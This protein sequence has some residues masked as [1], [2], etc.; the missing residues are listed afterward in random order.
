[1]ID[2]PQIV[3]SP[4]QLTAVI[5]LTIPRKEI[6][7]VM[8]PAI[9]EVMAAVAA[10]GIAPSGPV[11]S[12]HFRMDPGIFDFEVGVPIPK[13]VSPAG[14]VKPGQLPATTVARTVYHGPYEGLGAAWGEFDAWIAANGHT[15][16]PNLWERYVAGP[17]SG[18]DPANW[19][20]ELNRALTGQS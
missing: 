8:G 13:P 4:A 6:Q 16:A 18:P 11:F 3:Q 9:G 20:T 7:S 17:E 14:R 2:T 10:Q 12:H 19:R 5:R 15:P 1:M